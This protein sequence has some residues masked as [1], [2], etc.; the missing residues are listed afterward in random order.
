MRKMSKVSKFGQGSLGVVIPKTLCMA[1]DIRQGDIVIF[2]P[3][4]DGLKLEFRRMG[5][6]N[7]QRYSWKRLVGRMEE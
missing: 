5:E 1:Y 6:E 2:H 4:K 7:C 3:E